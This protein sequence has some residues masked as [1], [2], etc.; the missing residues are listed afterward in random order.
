VRELM[1]DPFVAELLPF[2]AELNG[3]QMSSIL[4][5]VRDLTMRPRRSA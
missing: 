5:Q 1:Q 2:V 3:M 4:T